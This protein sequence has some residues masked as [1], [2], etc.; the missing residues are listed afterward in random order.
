MKVYLETERLIIRDS[1]I[2]DFESTWEM[3]N[4]EDVTKFTGGITK[5]T[6]DEAFERYVKKCENIDNKLKE[7]S[8]ILKDSNEYIGYC[9]FQY[10]SVLDGIEIL[11][12][13]A[14]EHWGKG[15]A[16]EAAKVV[17]DFGINVLKLGEIVAAVNYKNIAS[18]KV[19]INIGMKY[20][21][22]VEWPEEGMVKKY[23]VEV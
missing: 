21:G 18:D 14:K 16:F 1:I 15:Y 10:C 13:Y 7:Y 6:R 19:L 22:D 12:G 3:R 5:L 2:D 11:Y 9:G 20:V 17:L 4:D 23:K 8:V